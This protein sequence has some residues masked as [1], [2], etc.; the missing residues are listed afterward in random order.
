MER[1]LDFEKLL[2]GDRLE[3]R[4]SDEIGVIAVDP[5]VTTGISI[6]TATKDPESRQWTAT[7]WGSHQLSYGGSGNTSDTQGVNSAWPEQDVASQIGTVFSLMSKE[8]PTALVIED[9]IIRKMNTSRDFLAPVRVTAGIMQH[10]YQWVPE[11]IAER[12]FFQTPADAKSI[13]TDERMDLWGF[14]ISS[15]K[16]RHSRDADRHA[17]LF[18]RRVSENPRKAA[19]LFTR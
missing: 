5:G 14:S 7:R 16:D 19:S 11:V 17:T 15:Q 2:N 12:H 9:F 4:H 10:I 6:M 1:T 8:I 3:K 13:C 18:L